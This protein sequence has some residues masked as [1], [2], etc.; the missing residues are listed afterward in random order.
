MIT[1]IIFGEKSFGIDPA[2]TVN[3]M[4]KF[5]N[6]TSR[7]NGI[8]PFSLLWRFDPIP[9]LGNYLQ[10]FAITI[11]DTPNSVGLLW[12]SDQPDTKTYK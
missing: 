6:F 1:E 4:P 2:S 5:R 8:F 10:G 7:K 12:T 11:L 3:R 9:G